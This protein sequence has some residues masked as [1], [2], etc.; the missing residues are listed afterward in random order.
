MRKQ[1]LAYEC[2][3]NGLEALDAYKRSPLRFYLV[4]MD[5]SMPVS[6]SHL[7]VNP[8]SMTDLFGSVGHGRV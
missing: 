7:C 8:R 5:M 4:L 2:A 3:V 6:I 1:G